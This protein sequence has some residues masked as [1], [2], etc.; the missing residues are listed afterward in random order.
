MLHQLLH[1]LRI[2]GLK[3][4]MC[5]TF[6][7]STKEYEIINYYEFINEIIIIIIIIIIMLLQSQQS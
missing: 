2:L 4:Y 1:Q 3:S 5:N 6:T 7:L